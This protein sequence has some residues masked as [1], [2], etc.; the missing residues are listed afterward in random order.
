V[1]CMSVVSAAPAASQNT[2]RRLERSLE[3]D[4]LVKRKIRIT[5][6]YFSTG[7]FFNQKLA[8]V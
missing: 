7:K 2:R 5:H 8:V 1:R 6:R 4:R 3:A